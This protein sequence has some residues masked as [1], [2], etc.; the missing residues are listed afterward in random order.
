MFSVGH[1]IFLDVEQFIYSF[2]SFRR[3]QN[4]LRF[5]KI[6]PI[7]FGNI[8]LFWESILQGGG[9]EGRGVLWVVVPS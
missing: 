9:V 6:K 8:Q 1:G 7:L 2:R 4:K 3:K 5:Y